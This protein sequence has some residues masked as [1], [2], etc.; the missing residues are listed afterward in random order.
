[1]FF[2]LVSEEG[3]DEEEGVLLLNQDV[4]D[5]LHCEDLHRQVGHCCLHLLVIVDKVT[6]DGTVVANEQ[7]EEN[8][9]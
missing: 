7:L 2:H 1:M 9:I 6:E 3:H 5:R 8:I 4:R